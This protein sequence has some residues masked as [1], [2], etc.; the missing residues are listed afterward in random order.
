MRTHQVCNLVM[1][2]M[3]ESAPITYDE[4]GAPGIC[5]KNV[6]K[7][8]LGIHDK[9]TG[10]SHIVILTRHRRDPGCLER[11][12]TATNQITKP[13]WVLAGL[14]DRVLQLHPHVILEIRL[15]NRKI[16]GLAGEL[17]GSP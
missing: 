10:V 8:V 11:V 5:P 15:R 3:R 13:E 12:F 14:C 6:G 1:G 17:N 16:I 7:P 9:S 4:R 2:A